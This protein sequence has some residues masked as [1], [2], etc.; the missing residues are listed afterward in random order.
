MPQR[1]IVGI[2]YGTSNSGAAYAL[3]ADGAGDGNVEIEVIKDWPHAASSHYASDKVPS[4][5][6]YGADKKPAG[7]GFDIPSDALNL[8]WVKLLLEPDDL[9]HK[10]AVNASRVWRSYE[11]LDEKHLNKKPVD[12]V[13]DY[14][15]WLW[16]IVKAKIER[17]EDDP[18]V[19]ENAQLTVVLTV[20]A[21]WSERAKYSM[22][23]AAK[24]AGM[25]ERSIKLISEP[26]AAAIFSLKKQAKKGQIQK[27][28]CVIVCDA[29][30]GTVDVVAYQVHSQD[31]LSLDQVTVS[32][33]D[34]CGSSF[35][36][37]EFHNQIKQILGE[38][39]Y[40]LDPEVKARIEDEFEYKIKRTYNPSEPK[41][42]HIPV[43]GLDDDEE[44][45]ICNG[46]MKIDEA[47]LSQAFESV[48][49]PIMTL[50][51]GQVATLKEKGHGDKIKGILLVGGF[52]GS[53]Y[54]HTRMREEFPGRNDIKIWRPDKTWTSVVQGAVACEAA[55]CGSLSVVHTRLS[56]YNYGVPYATDEGKKVKWLVRKGQPVQTNMATEPYGLRVDDQDWLDE[57]THCHL[58]V[59]LVRSE[60]DDALDDYGPLVT[61]HAEIDCRVPTHLRKSKE[62]RLIQE[63]PHKA[64]H[65]PATLVLFL[66]GAVISFRCR[67]NN[68]E[69]GVT[70]VTYY[71]EAPAEQDLRRTSTLSIPRSNNRADSVISHASS[72]SSR[73]N[74]SANASP[75]PSISPPSHSFS[76]SP[77]SRFFKPRAGTWLGVPTTIQ[78]K[79]EKKPKE[80]D[81]S[82]RSSTS[83]ETFD[84]ASFVPPQGLPA[85]DRK[86]S[87][88]GRKKSDK[89]VEYP[90]LF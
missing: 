73:S 29:G 60:E 50:I 3:S 71:R 55:G 28:D 87:G 16:R 36:D 6:A 1:L 88:D 45:D 11:Y 61:P 12:A 38:D 40:R 5:I 13:A 43:T 4:D 7:F 18:D 80:K 63:R 30:G 54:L 22:Q 33:G 41:Q 66:D 34:F 37:T 70:D 62:A 47:V 10:S 90:G 49:T 76:S 39:W 77:G 89:P 42:Y 20:P 59:P 69:V 31:P 9:R 21:T 83:S 2:D 81:K 82:K 72:A 57:D 19:L 74:S 23:R 32:K 68:E 65:I 15:R 46:K 25:P 78:T 75:R 53:E 86:P 48:M 58:L 44:R 64:W 85:Y 56:S 27:G 84:R 14:L 24:A 79:R 8:Q 67:I 35:V 51:D 52:S 17:D 26:E